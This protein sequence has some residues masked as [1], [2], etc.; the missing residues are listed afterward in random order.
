MLRFRTLAVAAAAAVG[1]SGALVASTISPA[2][3][4]GAAG[5]PAIGTQVLNMLCTSKAGSPV[6]TPMTIGRCQ[7]ARPRDGF[8]IEE[9]ICEGLLDGSVRAR[10][11]HQPS[12]QGQLVLLPHQAP[13]PLTIRPPAPTMAV[14]RRARSSDGTVSCTSSTNG[15]EP[16]GS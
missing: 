9:L 6:F 5:D 1:F 4:A 2:G 3:A 8:V 10:H 12:Q 15:C 7:D 16:V 11:Q 13:H 14:W